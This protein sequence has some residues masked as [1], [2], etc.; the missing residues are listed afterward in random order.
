MSAVFSFE[1][2][3]NKKD[4]EA[5]ERIHRRAAKVVRG[6]HK[7]Y[8]EQLRELRLFSLE[9]R[10]PWGDLTALYN[11]LKGGCGKVGASLFSHITSD[12]MRGNGLTF[13][14][15]RFRLDIRKNFFSRRGVRRWNRLSSEVVESPEGVQETWRC[16]TE[17]RG[18][19]GK[20]WW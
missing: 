13:C 12:R 1:L 3:T 14:Q 17:G 15:G 4:I 19:V 9:K 16:C 11:Y 2:L 8:E 10:R 18:L 20:Y 6:L 5:L 7:P